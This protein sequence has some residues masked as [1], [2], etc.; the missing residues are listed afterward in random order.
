MQKKSIP[1]LKEFTS[2]LDKLNLKDFQD[3]KNKILDNFANPQKITSDSLRKT[4]KYFLGSSFDKFSDDLNELKEISVLYEK[5][6]ISDK[7]FVTKIIESLEK[8]EKLFET[9]ENQRNVNLVRFADSSR[10]FLFI[11]FSGKD[12]ESAEFFMDKKK[13]NN[14]SKDKTLRAVVKLNMSKLGLLKA[15]LRLYDLNIIKIFF[16]VENNMVL[17][18]VEEGFKEL[19]F[20]LKK[21]G[22][23]EVFFHIST[24]EKEVL[25][26]S[27]IKEFLFDGKTD[28]NFNIVI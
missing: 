12:F 25:G 5:K 9:V 3:I 2:S 24:V 15:D 17:D 28:S 13:E 8:A 4:I 22:F 16:E 19:E 18:V 7:N 6:N 27:L 21:S 26:Q 1:A 14:Q 23:K 11:P 20:N 10:L